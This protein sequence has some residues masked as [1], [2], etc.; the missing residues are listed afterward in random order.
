METKK[1][2][3]GIFGPKK[4]KQDAIEE[5]RKPTLAFFFK[6][7][8]RKFPQLLRLNV[9]MIFQILPVI[10]IAVVFLA[11]DKTPTATSATFAPLY[12]INQS[13]SN[14]SVSQ[15]LDMASIQMGLPVFST[16]MNFIILALVVFMAITWGWQNVGATYVIR[17]LARGDAVFV[18]SDFFYAIKRNLKQGFFF[19][20]IDLALSAILVID[21]L[22]FYP[23]T[24]AS[25][26]IDFMYFA[27]FALAI[28][29]FIMRFYTYHL[30][31][32]FDMKNFKIIKNAFIFSILGIKR[33]IM[34]LI[35]I[36]AFVAI[37]I[38]VIM[39]LLSGPLGFII[40]LPVIYLLA[41]TAFMAGYAAYPIIDRYLIAPYAEEETEEF[42]YL[43]PDK[44]DQPSENE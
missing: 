27:I 19:G 11:G 14:P 41:V 1:K 4:D 15:T 40:I 31:I 9:L 10:V 34:A 37:H 28:I 22:F 32:T 26:G 13:I 17:G 38:A 18:F 5:N 8:V 43:T 3:F 30:L 7:F 36:V 44:P 2:K 33:N 24:G 20:L 29:Y 23:K 12:G 21:F 6:T 42:I 39:L 25:F 16:T 35:G